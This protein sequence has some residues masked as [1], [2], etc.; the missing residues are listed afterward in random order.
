[1]HL[2]DR[3]MF[4]DTAILQQKELVKLQ[5]PGTLALSHLIDWM[6]SP[7]MGTVYLLGLER[8][9]WTKTQPYELLA[10][11]RREHDDLLS[12]LITKIVRAWLHPA[13]GRYFKVNIDSNKLAGRPSNVSLLARPICAVH[14]ACHTLPELYSAHYLYHRSRSIVYTSSVLNPD[15][16]HRAQSTSPP[17]H[18][19]RF[20]RL[21]LSLSWASH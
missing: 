15:P 11:K 5:P 13:I 18:R 6:E 10:L 9:L 16:Q 12:S 20:Y 19:C 14:G 17:L 8:D 2:S 4:E 1:M 7:K 3:R 21:V